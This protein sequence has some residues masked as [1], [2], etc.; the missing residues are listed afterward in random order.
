VI[1]TLLLIASLL[2]PAAAP[3]PGVGVVAFENSGASGA[4]QVFLTGL[5]QLH[6]FEYDDA[7]KWFRKAEEIDPDFALA[8]W[9]EAMTF[10]HPVWMEQDIAAARRALKRLAG[11][12]DERLAKAKTPREKAYLRAVEILYGDGDK[13]ARD[14]AYADA[15]ADLHRAYPDDVDAAAFYALA[16]LGTAH[17]GRDAAT[18]MR[19]AALLEP[20]FPTHPGHPG[21]AH[22]LIHSYDD[23]VHAA[24]GLRAARAY[25][26]IAPSAGH[27]QHMCS[28]IFLA[29]G[30]WDDVVT[31][32]EAALRVVNAA[33]ASRGQ[34]PA[35]CGHYPSWLEYGY[36]QQGR[37]AAARQLLADCYKISREA[38]AQQTVGPA[39]RLA[40]D[41]LGIP[42]L[43]TMRARFLLDTEEWTS[44]VVA[45]TLPPSGRRDAEVLERF[46]EGYAA[47]RTGRRD[48][49]AAALERLRR[50]RT[51]LDAELTNAPPSDG[52]PA[53]ARAW[54]E[55][56]DFELSSLLQAARGETPAAIDGL[57]AA[58]HIEEKIPYEFGPPFVDKPSSE[59]LGEILLEAKRPAEAR[60]A[61]E[62]ALALSPAR[63]QA[64]VGLMRA[65]E[66][67][68]DAAKAAAIQAQLQSI[69][70]HAD[71]APRARP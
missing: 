68:G 35:A 55:I 40:P 70:R 12:A 60:A 39:P 33:R 25:S 59:L 47:L 3:V 66:Q 46:M 51:A 8:Y 71:R 10:N 18:Y 16:L 69:W 53:S 32:N 61:F 14:F 45:W 24:L 49:A 58:A 54:A 5:A 4:Q 62:K 56:L 29:M 30:M 34:P 38:V 48:E 23:P 26:A 19:A 57:R 6:N 9:G 17:E 13:Y 22:Y 27:A 50:A 44:E 42:S 63:T 1:P 52:T 64:L 28:H 21:I 2:Q 36:L 11:T 65:A 7:A 37:I 31:A 20:L 67:S 41:K 43:L 15:M